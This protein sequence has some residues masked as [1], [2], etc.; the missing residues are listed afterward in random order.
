MHGPV[1][2]REPRLG[3]RVARLLDFGQHV[4][5]QLLKLVGARHEIGLAVHF[6]ERAGRVVVGQ[7]VS[8]QAF[9]GGAAGFLGRARQAAL[10]Q[11]GVRFLEIAVRLREG[12]LHSI[13]PAPVWSR[14]FLT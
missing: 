9:A 13:M 11:D 8:D 4:V 5:D 10:A 3:R 2:V 1:R 12:A 14:S 7:A 6:D